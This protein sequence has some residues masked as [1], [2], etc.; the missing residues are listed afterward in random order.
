MHMDIFNSDAFSLS[1]MTAAIEKMPSVPSYL[2][3]LN[4]F[5]EE[6][7]PTDTVTIE[8]KDL[9][10]SPIT[11]SQRG[12]QP[13]MG[14]TEKAKLRSFSIPRI[15]KSDQV[16]AREIQG[17]R[18]FGTEGELLT[19]MRL[20]GQKQAKLLTEFAL[21]EELHRLG[22]LQGILLDADGS[23]LYNFFTEF[24]ISQPAEID[25]NLDAVSPVE[26]VLR[27]LVSDSV[28]RPI[29]RAL[30]SSW[31]PG[32]RIQALCGDTFYDQFVNHND[33]RVTYKNW[34][35]AQSLRSS[36]AFESFTFAGVDWV[37]YKGT[38]DNST[39]AISTTK[40][41]FFVTGVPGLFRRINGPGEDFETVNTIGRRIYSMLVR[42]LQRN[43]WVQPEIYAYPLH[44]CT[45]P[46]ILLRGKNT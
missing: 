11:T 19:A 17:V 45:R 4:L 13:G 42:D 26:G 43:Q 1:S 30:Q 7:V 18:A 9:V 5:T 27:S 37:N 20:I 33:V 6:G 25:F 21:T 46:E 44:M 22:A 24:G 2:G 41:K 15:A 34:E 12:T 3:S 29:A 35:A 39:V 16:F 40:V 36:T 23:T 31:N 8:S 28:V 14:T 32:V 10:L 38:D